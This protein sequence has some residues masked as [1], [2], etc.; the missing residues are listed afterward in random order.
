MLPFITVTG[1]PTVVPVP[2]HVEP[3]KKLYV[4]VPPAWKLP[5]KV[6]ASVTDWP[7]VTVFLERVVDSVGA[8]LVTVTLKL[9]ELPEWL[10]SVL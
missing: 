2:L 1:L 7:T 6:A 4:T 9:P 10:E 5:V 3:A 8:V